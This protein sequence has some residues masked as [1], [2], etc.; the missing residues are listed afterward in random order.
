MFKFDEDHIIPN[1]GMLINCQTHFYHVISLPRILPRI[2][3]ETN[4]ILLWREHMDGA[5]RLVEVRF[6]PFTFG[7]FTRRHTCSLW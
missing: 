5:A 4:L 6:V 3:S 7:T 2:A 1:D